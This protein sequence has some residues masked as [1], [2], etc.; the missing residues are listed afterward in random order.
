MKTKIIIGL[1]YGDEGK[2]ITTDYLCRHSENP[3]VVRF[4][5]G[6]QAG[7]TVVNEEGIRHVFSSFGAGT[8]L[9][10]PT[11]WSKYCTMYPIHFYNELS[12]LLE[13]G[14]RPKIYMDNMTLVT[15]PYD[16]FM[17]RNSEKI[18]QHGS[19]GLGFG[20]TVTRD[21]S[22]PYKLYAKDLFYPVVL[23]KKLNAIKIYYQNKTNSEYDDD[24][25][26]KMMEMYQKMII[27]ILP[28]IDIVSEKEFFN[29]ILKKEKTSDL[30]FEGSQGILLDMDHGFFPNVTYANTVSKNAMDLIE[31]YNLENPELY[32]I[33]RAYQTRHG[34]GFL[35]N[36]NLELN[37]TPNPNETNQFNPWQ[38]HQRLS[39][40][41]LDLLEYAIQSDESFSYGM[42]KN[43]VITCLDQ[44]NGNIKASRGAEIK[45]FVGTLDLVRELGFEFNSIIESWG[46][47]S[48]KMQ[49]R[50]LDSELI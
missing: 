46:E 16:V 40:L 29:S 18:N 33:T 38:G 2:G 44:M 28:Y 19:C 50:I 42:Q 37:I 6:H 34:N 17:N 8:L 39:I 10:V 30:I 48:S 21:V 32:Y 25:F 47:C 11:Y 27:D 15:T 12:S 20:A 3:L 7:H 1:G 49:E 41:D 5:G 24:E 45:E 4:S 26:L 13:K 14:I 35:S 9:G 36:E 22:S 23:E 31:Y 43:L